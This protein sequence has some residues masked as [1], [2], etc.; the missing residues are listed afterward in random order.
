[1]KGAEKKENMRKR[2]EKEEPLEEK[3]PEGRVDRASW[4][5]AGRYSGCWPWPWPCFCLDGLLSYHS[6]HVR[7]EM[8]SPV[9]R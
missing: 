5:S 3:V 9:L 4:G 2:E 1:M 7:E 6:K 8:L